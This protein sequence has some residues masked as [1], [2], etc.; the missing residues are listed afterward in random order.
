M[1]I[2]PETGEVAEINMDTLEGYQA[3]VRSTKAYDP[4]YQ[5]VYP[6]LGLANEAGEVAGKLKK[7]MR[8]ENGQLSQESF[9]ALVAELGDVLWYVTATADDLGI[10]I[11]DIFYENYQKLSSRKARGVIKGSGD[12]R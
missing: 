9:K 6:I 5:L 10:T 3:F 11:S 4:E 2:N 1:D 7:I 8:D 12:N